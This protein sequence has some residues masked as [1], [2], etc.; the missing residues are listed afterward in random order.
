MDKR[1]LILCTE[2][3]WC[4]IYTALRKELDRILQMDDAKQSEAASLLQSAIDTMQAALS[5][6]AL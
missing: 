2:E 6:K 3:E 4:T 1:Y 5:V